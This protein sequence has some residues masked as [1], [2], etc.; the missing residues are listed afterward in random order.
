MVNFKKASI[1]LFLF[2]TCI[3]LKASVGIDKFFI[4]P[5]AIIAVSKNYA[6][7]LEEAGLYYRG[8]TKA[9]SD[10]IAIRI[11]RGELKNKPFEIYLND[12]II[13]CPHFS[14]T[15]NPR[16]YF[17]QTGRVLSLNELMCLVDEFT[18]PGFTA[19]DLWVCGGDDK[20]EEETFNR[21]EKRLLSKQLPKADIDAI[22]SKE[23]TIFELNELTLRYKNDSVICY[24][25]DIEVKH[26]LAGLPIA[27]ND[28]YILQECGVFRVYQHSE[29]IK[30]FKYKN[31]D[32]W[33]CDYMHAEVFSKWIN[34]T[35]DGSYVGYSYSYDKNRFYLI[36]N[37]E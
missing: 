19:I 22:K 31:E 1:F 20:I 27:I 35:G 17:I 25:N 30:T 10:Y 12:A 14:L 37:N 7:G 23:H 13:S 16:A 2:I 15:Q 3:Q 24:I 18:K 26:K 6:R 4:E 28:R 34:F 33:Y 29:L 11:E 9:L 8:V 21:I 36:E 5:N 32:L